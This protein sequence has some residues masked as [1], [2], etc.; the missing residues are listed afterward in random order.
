M[1]NQKITSEITNDEDAIEYALRPGISGTHN[2]SKAGDVERTELEIGSHHAGLGLTVVSELVTRSSGYMHLVSGKAGR[3]INKNGVSKDRI[4]GW[5][6]TTI[7]FNIDCE[8][9]PNVMQIIKDV[10][11]Q[12]PDT[13]DVGLK[14]EN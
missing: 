6:G 8:N 4:G 3:F 11:G 7:F 10:G 9:I 5:P 1:G 14:I 12:K 2:R 13:G